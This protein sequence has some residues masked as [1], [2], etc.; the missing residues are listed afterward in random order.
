M[1]REERDEFFVGYL[2]VMPAG[3]ARVLRARA[4][5]ILVVTSGL[6]VLLAALL[7]ATPGGRFEYGEARS[8]EGRVLATPYPQL[9]VS[10]GPASRT[11]LLVARGKHGAQSLVR[12]LDGVAV[13][14]DG[15]L[16]ERDGQTMLELSGPPVRMEGAATATAVEPEPLGR[17]TLEGEIVDSKCHL[18]VMVPGEGRTHRGCAV[19]CISGGAP[20]L[21]VAHDS[22]GTT[23]RLLLTDAGGGPVG[24]RILDL[25]AVPVRITGEMSRR[26]GLLYL[27]ADP[28][29]YERIP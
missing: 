3:L 14:V 28:S 20:P 22:A 5:A 29:T 7:P 19:R 24:S 26:A 13:R 4:L 6:A 16:I 25:V 23:M 12:D 18:G 9:V 15:S 10:D 8:W 1:N 11:F 27:A 17:V 2:P 21:L